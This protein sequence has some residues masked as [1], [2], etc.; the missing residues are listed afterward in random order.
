MLMLK[1]DSTGGG[2]GGGG[3]DIRGVGTTADG[4]VR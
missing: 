3:A 1:G 2:G 4:M